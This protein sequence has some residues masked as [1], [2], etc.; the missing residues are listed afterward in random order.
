MKRMV[1]LSVDIGATPEEKSIPGAREHTTAVKPVADFTRAWRR[2]LGAARCG[3][4]PSG[5]G[6][7]GAGCG[8]VE[9]TL[10]LHHRPCLDGHG[11]VPRTAFHILADTATNRH[12]TARSFALRQVQIRTHI[13]RARHHRSCRQQSEAHRRRHG[14]PAEGGAAR[15][16]S[17]HPRYRLKRATLALHYRSADRRARIR[18]GER[19]AAVALPSERLCRRRRGNGCGAGRI[20]LTAA[21]WRSIAPPPAWDAGNEAA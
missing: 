13:A 18:H 10:A 9:I 17:R 3:N 1:L 12:Y 2:I 7:V 4:G 11:A 14:A 19:S 20:A 15:G 5:I 21:S 16:R 6:V 8:R